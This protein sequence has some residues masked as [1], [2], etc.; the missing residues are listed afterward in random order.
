MDAKPEV[1]NKRRNR[2]AATILLC[3]WL[4]SKGKTDRKRN[5]KKSKTN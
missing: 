3:L 5:K 4:V 1:G 2:K